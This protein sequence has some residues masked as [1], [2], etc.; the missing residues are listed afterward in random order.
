MLHILRYLLCSLLDGSCN[1]IGFATGGRSG[2]DVQII[3][4]RQGC[5]LSQLRTGHHDET[6]G[7]LADLLE[8]GIDGVN[9]C[10]DLPGPILLERGGPRC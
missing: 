1:W 6:L 8:P 7:V 2:R 10:L 4:D 9:S 3:E 5:W